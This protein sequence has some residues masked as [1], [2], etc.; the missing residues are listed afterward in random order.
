MTLEQRKQVVAEAR[1]WLHTPYH[2]QANVKGAGVDCIML[3]IEVYAAC[4]L[5][6]R[7]DPRPYSPDWHMHRGDEIYLGG[8]E[9]YAER[10]GAPQPGD[11]ALFQFG[12]CISHGAIVVEWP[13]VIHAFLDNRCV[14]ETDI[15]K[16]AD[17]TKRLRYFYR[18][19]D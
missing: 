11:I 8:I 3:L 16:S 14:V 12:R 1:T 18:L 6:E 13:L 15:S 4:G 9:R 7:T 17:L 19:K 5:V 10:V 2:H